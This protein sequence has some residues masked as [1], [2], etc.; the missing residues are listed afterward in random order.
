MQCVF[1][2]PINFLSVKAERLKPPLAVSTILFFFLLAV[3][4]GYKLKFSHW[5]WP[6]GPV[7]DPIPYFSTQTCRKFCTKTTY[8]PSPSWWLSPWIQTP[9]LF[10][11]WAA[12]PTRVPFHST[13][14][15]CTVRWEQRARNWGVDHLLQLDAVTVCLE[16]EAVNK[17][18]MCS[19][20]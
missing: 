9:F 3:N 15:I 4:V 6:L 16:M 20:Q 12:M 11:T 10:L 14:Q 2:V 19:V 17:S 1:V 8:T 13:H 5:H 18:S 7:P